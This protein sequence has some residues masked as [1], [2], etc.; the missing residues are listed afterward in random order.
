MKRSC[1]NAKKTTR[2][3]IAKSNEKEKKSFTFSLEIQEKIIS[4]CDVKT[5]YLLMQTCEHFNE[6]CKENEIWKLILHQLRVQD[7]PL[8]YFRCCKIAATNQKV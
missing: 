7:E 3:K 8:S 1:S 2:S 5:I 6:I 4:F